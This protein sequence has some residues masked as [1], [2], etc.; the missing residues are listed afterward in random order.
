MNNLE[1]ALAEFMYSL[2]PEDLSKLA[3]LKKP[4]NGRA[5]AYRALQKQLPKIRLVFIRKVN[6]LTEYGEIYRIKPYIIKRNINRYSRIIKAIDIL[7]EM[8]E[9]EVRY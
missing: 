6:W 8:E 4:I 1:K 2:Q 3:A 5:Q 9:R 7:M